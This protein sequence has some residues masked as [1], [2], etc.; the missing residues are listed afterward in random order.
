MNL[1]SPRPDVSSDMPPGE[2]VVDEIAFAPCVDVQSV[3]L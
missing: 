3:L 1:I 2:L